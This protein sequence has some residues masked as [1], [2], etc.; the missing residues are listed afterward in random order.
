MSG[1]RAILAAVLVTCLGSAA[2]AQPAVSRAVEVAPPKGWTPDMPLFAP[3]E[4]GGTPGH[5]APAHSRDNAV[6]ARATAARPPVHA[7]KD[8]V[9]PARPVSGDGASRAKSAARPAAARAAVAREATVSARRSEPGSRAEAVRAADRV[10]KRAEA[11][12][13][14]SLGG[15]A[16]K[17]DRAPVARQTGPASTA[18]KAMGPA[19]ADARVA[20][21]SAPTE[22]RRGRGATPLAPTRATVRGAGRADMP[23]PRARSGTASRAEAP[24]AGAPVKRAT[25]PPSEA[26]PRGTVRAKGARASR[27]PASVPAP[28]PNR[29]GKAAPSKAAARVAH[30]R[31]AA[32]SPKQTKA[33]PA[34]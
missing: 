16:V 33:R 15:V 30:A 25:V 14:K 12:R 8:R 28:R 32:A 11:R 4:E 19:R 24:K 2:F 10:E 27:D 7:V 29:A 20:A 13:A 22:T 1:R 31:A 23:S 26:V 5:K 3:E 6:T 34:R 18:R 21:Q 9:E 17:A